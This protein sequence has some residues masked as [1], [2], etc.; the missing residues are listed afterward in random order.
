MMLMNAGPRRIHQ[1]GPEHSD[2]SRVGRC[3]LGRIHRGALA[4]GVHGLVGLVFLVA[5]GCHTLPDVQPFADATAAIH[6]TISA[7]GQTATTQLAAIEDKNAAPATITAAPSTPLAKK[8][9]LDWSRREKMFAAMDTYAASLVALVRAGEQGGDAAKSLATSA[10]ELAKSVT[11]SFPGADPALDL[12]TSLAAQAYDI[13]AKEI[14]AR[15]LGKAIEAEE[16]TIQAVANLVCADLAD[17]KRLNVVARD[18]VLSKIVMSTNDLPRY[19][20]LVQMRRNLDLRDPA[21]LPK[22]KELG[23]L[24][25]H[26]TNSPWYIEYTQQRDDAMSQFQKTDAVIDQALLAV[27]A[28]AQAHTNIGVAVREKRAPS[29]AELQQVTVELLTAYQEYRTQSGKGK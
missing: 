25:D 18:S 22:L 19:N 29:L 21:N 3:G 6:H 8:F 16:Q 14:A 12:V 23:E 2:R 1:S 9:Q 13:I 4:R 11:S 5:A 27:R 20:S 24:L 28:W 15:E 10:K 26:E 17:L 7:T